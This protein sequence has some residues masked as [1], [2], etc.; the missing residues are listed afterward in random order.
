MRYKKKS[1][2]YLLLLELQPGCEDLEHSNAT[3]VYGSHYLAWSSTW[4]T[5]TS[6]H[7]IIKTFCIFEG[8]LISKIRGPSTQHS[9]FMDR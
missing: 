7:C 5:D 6:T 9:V 2:G 1:H 3:G 8:K 4:T